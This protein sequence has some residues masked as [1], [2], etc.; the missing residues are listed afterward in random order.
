MVLW[1]EEALECSQPGG[2]MMFTGV[3][4]QMLHYGS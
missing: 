1:P 2:G 4:Y 3:T